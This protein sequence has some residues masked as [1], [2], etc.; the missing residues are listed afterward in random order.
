MT[1][2][3]LSNFSVLKSPTSPEGKAAQADP[4]C[5]GGPGRWW[6]V[7]GRMEFSRFFP[8][9]HRLEKE[10]PVRHQ[11]KEAWTI[12]Q[13]LGDAA[14]V[15]KGRGGMPAGSIQ[16]KLQIPKS[17]FQVPV[18]QYLLVNDHRMTINDQ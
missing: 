7:G 2:D 6:L 18:S 16:I 11:D 17:E 10:V 12:K 1:I 5:S 3:Q 14:P 13:T 4:E 9:F 8:P 15:K